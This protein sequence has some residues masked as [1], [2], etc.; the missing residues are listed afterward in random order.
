MHAFDRT[1]AISED[2]FVDIP[3]GRDQSLGVF[4]LVRV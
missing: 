3:H 2:S 4:S 1:T